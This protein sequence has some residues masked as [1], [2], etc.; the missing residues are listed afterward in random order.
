MEIKQSIKEDVLKTCPR[1]GC[2]DFKRLV[3]LN[4][5]PWIIYGAKES[6]GYAPQIPNE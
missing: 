2:S 4:D 6:N 1:C 5:N 3:C